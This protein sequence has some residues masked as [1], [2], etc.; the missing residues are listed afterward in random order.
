MDSLQTGDVPVLDATLESFPANFHEP[1]YESYL[2]EDL[3][4][5]FREAGLEPVSADPIFLSK[6]IVCSKPV[7]LVTPTLA[8]M[9]LSVPT[10][11]RRFAPAQQI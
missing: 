9:T 5:I 7:S 6:R 11:L 1:F 3:S 10:S 4:G 8:G 2:G